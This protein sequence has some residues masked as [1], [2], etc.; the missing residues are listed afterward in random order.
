[1]KNNID[2]KIIGIDLGFSTSPT[3][4]SVLDNLLDSNWGDRQHIKNIFLL[5]PFL[6]YV[7]NCSNKILSR[8]IISTA[9]RHL[10]DIERPHLV[11]VERPFLQGVGNVDFNKFLGIFENEIVNCPYV[12]L[13]PTSIKKCLGS[14]KLEKKDM[15]NILLDIFKHKVDKKIIRRAIKKEDWDVT[16]SVAIG[17]AGL[18]AIGSLVKL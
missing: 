12:Y 1:M 13:A 15:A 16:D 8:K 9:I 5:G 6:N 2:N 7:D 4:V 3:C 10:I 11:V 14:G 18:M 17:L